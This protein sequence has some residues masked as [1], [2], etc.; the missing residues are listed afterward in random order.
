MGIEARRAAAA[1]GGGGGGG[2]RW[3]NRVE[4]VEERRRENL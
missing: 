1:G 2:G 4:T 3:S